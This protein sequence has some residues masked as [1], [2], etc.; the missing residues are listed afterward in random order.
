MGRLVQ[1]PWGHAKLEIPSKY[2]ERKEAT[3]RRGVEED[4]IDYD[5]R[6]VDDA[7]SLGAKTFCPCTARVSRVL[8]SK[9]WF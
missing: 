2:P 8:E 7:L 5:E 1:F 6:S 9:G 3:I 4:M